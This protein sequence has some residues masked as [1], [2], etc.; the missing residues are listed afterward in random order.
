MRCLQQ[1]SWDRIVIQGW[2]VSC[3]VHV[4]FTLTAARTLTPAAGRAV[5]E[6]TLEV[7]FADEPDRQAEMELVVP[8]ELARSDDVY[9]T[10]FVDPMVELVNDQLEAD[11]AR[12]VVPPSR[13][14][15]AQ[16]DRSADGAGE[17]Q[18]VEVAPPGTTAE[19]FGTLARGDR[20]IYVLDKSGSMSSGG[21]GEGSPL[22]RYQRA[23]QELLAS[24]DK[25]TEDQYFCVILFSNT[26]RHMQER[27]RRRPQMLPATVEN[28]V[29]L[30]D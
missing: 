16:R 11:D 20:F 9:E 6:Q 8:V 2:I 14:G 7:T 12:L 13:S 29:L 18:G 1:V 21:G 5:G 27:G 19:F 25:L 17:R 26:N 24:I 28:K 30:R 4:V 23:L 22:N 3:V 10:A 15:A